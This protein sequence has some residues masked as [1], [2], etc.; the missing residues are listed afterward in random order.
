MV[1]GLGGGVLLAAANNFTV[2]GNV[3]EAVLAGVEEGFEALGLAIGLNGPDA[4]LAAGFGGVALAGLDDFAVASTQMV[5]VL[6][7][8]LKDLE[9]CHSGSKKR[10]GEMNSS[11]LSGQRQRRGHCERNG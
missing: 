1:A 11:K 10:V 2:G 8:A 6:A 5:P 4:V 3:V 9:G 7:A